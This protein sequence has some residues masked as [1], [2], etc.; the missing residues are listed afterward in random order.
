MSNLPRGLQSTLRAKCFASAVIIMAGG[1]SFDAAAAQSG[2]DSRG[3]VK[4]NSCQVDGVPGPIRCGT[5]EV[6][7]DR[8]AGRGR[9]ISLKIIVLAAAESKHE[10][11][12][13]FILAGARGRLQQRTRNSSRKPSTRYAVHETLSLLTSGARADPM[14]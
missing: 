8:D 11:D 5:Y 14:A 6:F 7:E 2:S 3:T 13:L 9:R 10:P 12:P 1:A 4:L